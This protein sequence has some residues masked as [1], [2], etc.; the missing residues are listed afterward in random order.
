M[1]RALTLRRS[2]SRN[3]GQVGPTTLSV[4]C[5]LHRDGATLLVGAIIINK[6]MAWPRVPKCDPATPIFS[7]ATLNT[8]FSIQRS[9]LELYRHYINNCIGTTSSTSKNL[10]QFITAVNSFHLALKYTWEISDSSLTFLHIKVSTFDVPVYTTNPQIL[11]VICC[12]HLHIYHM[13]RILFLILSFLDFVAFV[14][15]TLIFP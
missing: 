10:N 6:S 15:T 13:S 7:Q 5:G 2:E 14:V 12:F 11:I 1:F 3:C 9:Q 4:V 8:N